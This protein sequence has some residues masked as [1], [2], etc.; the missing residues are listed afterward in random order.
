MEKFSK[1]LES[2]MSVFT[3]QLTM[4]R[5][6]KYIWKL[7]IICVLITLILMTF[8]ISFPYFGQEKIDLSSE[9]GYSLGSISP[10]TIISTREIVYDDPQRTQIEKSKAY[11]SGNYVFER[12]Y[13]YL[14]N[15]VYSTIDEELNNLKS[16]GSINSTKNI[17]QLISKNPRWKF[18]TKEDLEALILNPEKDR[19]KELIQQCTN[20]IFSSTCI[21]KDSPVILPNMK[22]YGGKVHNRGIKDK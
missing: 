12:D 9:G 1:L 3:D 20:I 7:Q 6:S 15:I 14:S 17:Q 22:T 4:I 18:K 5:T 13:T 10:E 16:I 2:N 21:L 8:F 11:N 19:L